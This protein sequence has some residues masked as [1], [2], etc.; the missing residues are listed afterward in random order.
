MRRYKTIIIGGG[1]SGLACGLTL[2]KAKEDFLLLTKNLGGRMLASGKINYG[3]SYITSEYKLTSE[4]IGRGER[5][6]ANDAYFFD[7]KSWTTVY[8]LRNLWGLLI[9][10]FK[11]KSLVK[12]LRVFR[13]KC[14]NMEQKDA[15][16][17]LLKEYL[18]KTPKDFVK[19]YNLSYLNKFF[20]K[21]VLE[22]TFFTP[23]DKV[24]LL[25]Y[26]VVLFP[27]VLPT[28]RADFSKT[29]PKLT[30]GWKNKIRKEAVLSLKKNKKYIVKT[31]KGSYEAD[32]IVLALPYRYAK[33][34]WKVPRPKYPGIT[35]YAWHIKG[36]RDDKKFIFFDEKKYGIYC[37]WR[38][39]D[40]TDLMFSKKPHPDLRKVYK[41]YKV[42]S[43]VFWDP[44]VI[45]SGKK[46][47]KQKLSDSM[48]VAGDYNISCLEDSFITGVYAANQIISSSRS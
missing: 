2:N 24:N 47:V 45:L 5:I 23:I 34:L 38:Q 11:I 39:E 13:K 20:A 19:E 21:P 28:Y 25:Q 35:C 44:A 42:L 4:F 32:N 15:L 46:W 33:K 22:S 36:D 14:L 12:D 43:K 1:I 6:S 37:I 29:I 18:S 16:T 17:P 26:F 31:S 8:K 3:A 9:L 48:F 7:G 10:R 40:G 27:A 41:K 30:K